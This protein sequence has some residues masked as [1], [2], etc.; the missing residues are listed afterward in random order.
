MIREKR[1]SIRTSV[2]AV[3]DSDEPSTRHASM[4]V[5]GL[6]LVDSIDS[7]GAINVAMDGMTKAGTRPMAGV[8]PTRSDFG[9]DLCALAAPVKLRTY[10]WYAKKEG[11]FSLFHGAPAGGEGDGGKSD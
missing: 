2:T 11:R 5:N 6:S 4:H 7:Q 1:L 9:K 3:S 10:R 8:H